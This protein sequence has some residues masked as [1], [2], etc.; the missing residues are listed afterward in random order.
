M[1]SLGHGHTDH[2]SITTSKYHWRINRFLISTCIGLS[3]HDDVYDGKTQSQI[4]EK[5]T[6]G[7]EYIC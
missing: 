7:G 3:N 4:A 1:A 2:W 6:K 5:K